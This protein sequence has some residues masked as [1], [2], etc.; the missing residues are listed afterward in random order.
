VLQ[1]LRHSP[2]LDNSVVSYT[3]SNLTIRLS[4]SY[5]DSVN[6]SPPKKVYPKTPP[7]KLI[8]KDKFDE[9][10]TEGNQIKLRSQSPLEYVAK[11]LN[12]GSVNKRKSDG[13][14]DTEP[15]VKK[16]RK[17]ADDDI[18]EQNVSLLSQG[19]GESSHS[20][21]SR[22]KPK[23]IINNGG[24]ESHTSETEISSTVLSEKSLSETPIIPT[25]SEENDKVFTKSV[26]ETT[27]K[28][29]EQNIRGK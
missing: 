21:R 11:R 26:Q 12:L 17:N 3:D 16:N 29:K 6:D 2:R 9:V 5:K 4:T 14:L 22:D 13:V 25:T 1:P 15:D 18:I 27:A 20:L 8:P 10:P 24:N 23:E 7:K 28:L 19:D